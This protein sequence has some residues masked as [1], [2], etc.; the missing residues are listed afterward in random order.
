[1]NLCVNTSCNMLIREIYSGRYTAYIRVIPLPLCMNSVAH[2]AIQ[3]LHCIQYAVYTV[4]CTLI[5][6]YKDHSIGNTNSRY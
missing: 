4:Q 5:N 1:M 3:I 2:Y 6:I